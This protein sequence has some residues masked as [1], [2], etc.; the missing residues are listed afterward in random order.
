ML[1]P[2]AE[3]CPPLKLLVS[4]LLGTKLIRQT[5]DLTHCCPLIHLL[6]PTEKKTLYLIYNIKIFQPKEFFPLFLFGIYL[7][8]YLWL[9]GENYSLNLNSTSFYHLLNDSFLVS[10]PFSPSSW[11]HDGNPNWTLL[12]DKVQHD[13]NYISGDWREP[14]SFQTI[15]VF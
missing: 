2:P 10:C 1:L 14:Y 12:C 8:F 7:C 15:N 11:N 9:S 6:L 13:K 4:K 3:S 5:T